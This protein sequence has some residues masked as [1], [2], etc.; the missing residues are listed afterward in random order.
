MR[1]TRMTKKFF[2]APSILLIVL[3]C[4]L[5]IQGSD[6]FADQ[7]KSDVGIS[8]DPSKEVEKPEPPIYEPKPPGGLDK[9]SALPHLGQMVTSFILL[10]IGVSCLIVGIGI[11]GL[12]KVYYSE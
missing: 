3:L 11:I 9:N 2:I 8:F 7:G 6:V 5:F 12:R 4:T 1:V 10:L